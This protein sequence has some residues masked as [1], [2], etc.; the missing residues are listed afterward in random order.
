MPRL[1]LTE[2][3]TTQGIPLTLQECDDLRRLHD[4]IRVEPTRGRPGR[5][6]LTP[7][8]QVG[9]VC[10][11]SQIIEIRPKMPMA[12]VLFLVSYACD[13]VKWA[14]PPAE[15][16]HETDLVELLAIMLARW[17]QHA[18]RQGLLNGYRLEEEALRGPRGRILFDQQL[19]RWF[20]RTPPIEVRHDLF[21]S[22]ILENRMLLAA[23]LAMRRFQSR[24]KSIKHE[25]S[26]AQRLFGGVTAKY[27]APNAVPTVIFTRLNRHY[28]SALSLATIL[29]QSASLELGA[30]GAQ[31]SSFLVDMNVVFERF[32][33][34]A[35]RK[36]L[37]LDPVRFPDKLSGIY[38]DE[39][40]VVH[41]RPDLC[42]VERGRI[43]WVGDAKYKF[44][45][46]AANLNADLYQLLAYTVALDLPNGLLIYASNKGTSE[47]EHAVVNGGQRLRVVA[48]DLS[49]PPGKILQQIGEIA[50]GIEHSAQ[51]RQSGLDEIGTAGNA[52]V[53]GRHSTRFPTLAHFAT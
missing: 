29:L 48:L 5:Y 36:S 37:N 38:L 45:P 44:L 19:R 49:M 1:T 23:L 39:N 52:E 2:F 13:F 24:Q 43:I 17:V 41:L 33:R 35:L 32:V 53:S 42:I 14:N 28:Q 12:S 34:T 4:G 47:A 3:Q 31:G 50:R 11:S 10:L 27:Y 21:T 40:S 9:V 22:D 51:A 7:N 20:G 18:T 46:I 26:R 16:T 6:D 15:F 25:I 30:G 8:Q